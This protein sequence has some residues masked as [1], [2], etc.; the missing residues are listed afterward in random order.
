MGQPL[1]TLRTMPVPRI[2]CTRVHSGGRLRRQ[3]PP[4]GR[5]PEQIPPTP[6]Q[7]AHSLTPN[8][9]PPP[10]AR[11]VPAAVRA[12]AE[13]AAGA[14]RGRVR[15]ERQYMQYMR[16]APDSIISR[17]RSL[18]SRVRSPTPAN[19]EK[20]PAG[21]KERRA[22]R[23]GG[24]RRGRHQLRSRLPAELRPEGAGSPHTTRSPCRARSSTRGAAATAPGTRCTSPRS[25][26]I[27]AGKAQPSPA[28][29]PTTPSPRCQSAPNAAHHFPRRRKKPAAGPVPLTV[30]LGRV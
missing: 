29:A 28:A 5:R 24:Q 13:A 10:V 30:P 4:P 3:L 17:Y 15:H 8:T 9:Q 20:P 11:S 7:Q 25:A 23:R 6:L 12:A 16:Y 27:H 22:W 19:T 1:H 26:L 21:R 2:C 14:A 18:P